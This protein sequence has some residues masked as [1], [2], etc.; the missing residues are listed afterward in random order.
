MPCHSWQY[1]KRIL[2]LWNLDQQSATRFCDIDQTSDFSLL[3]FNIFLESWY[4]VIVDYLSDEESSLKKCL[5]WYAMMYTLCCSLLSLLFLLSNLSVWT[6][7]SIQAL[8]CC[9]V[10]AS[11]LNHMRTVWKLQHF[12]FRRLLCCINLQKL[13]IL[14]VW[15]H[16]LQ[17]S[18]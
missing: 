16:R 17:N 1:L 11:F 3:S 14:Y 4:Y 13:L 18:S 15:Q 6:L 5:N 12:I 8:L 7:L 2:T 10:I 9:K